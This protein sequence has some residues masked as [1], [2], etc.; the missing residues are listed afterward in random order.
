MWDYQQATSWLSGILEAEGTCGGTGNR[1]VIRLANT[2][3]DVINACSFYFKQHGILYR[4]YEKPA[5]TNRKRLVSLAI[6]GQ[7]SEAL[8]RLLGESFQC[9]REEFQRKLGA[10]TTTS[11][12][13]II[14]PDKHWLA[15][16]FEGEGCFVL[17]ESFS[18][19]S[20]A[21]RFVNTNERILEKYALTLKQFGVPWYVS[22]RV[23]STEITIGGMLRS[24][25]FLREFGKL[26]RSSRYA[27]R[28][29]KLSEYIES[30]LLVPKGSPYSENEI[31]IY[32]YLR[33]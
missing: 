23:N 28:A 33:G 29:E 10:S 26:W 5:S 25:K 31:Q 7:D 22:K 3:L 9:R 17:R 27:K 14:T 18:S 16:I 12:T 6:H 2:D 24:R 32:H 30:R 11:S 21:I 20:P 1:R 19:Y 8:M 15:G 13:P 4:V